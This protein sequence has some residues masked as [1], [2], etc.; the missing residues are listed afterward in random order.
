MAQRPGGR[1]DPRKVIAR[2][3]LI[4]PLRLHLNPAWVRL[5][6]LLALIG[7]LA[8]RIWRWRAALSFGALSAMLYG[9][10]SR[11]EPQRPVLE[12][13]TLFPQRLTVA[14]DGLRIGQISDT[15][16]GFR[17]TEANLAWAVAQ[18]RIE[19]PDLIVLTGDFV[20]TASAIPRLAPLLRDLHAPLGVYAVLGNH[21]DW[22]GAGDVAAA[23]TLCGI[24]LL[25]NTQCL[26]VWQGAALRIAG[27]DDVWLGAL[28][29]RQT[30]GGLPDDVFTILLA[31][32]PDVV[33]ESARY[34]VD[35]QLSGHSH[36]GQL[37][38]PLLG[39]LSAPRYGRRY[40]IG[41]HQVGPTT[42]YISRGSGGVPL[43]LLCPPEAT[44][45]TLRRRG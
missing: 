33:T 44:I 18:M 28:D 16:L 21:D 1:Q 34:G 38:L 10:M 26:H 15:H 4:D 24:T 30:L 12:R 41:T 22:E 43:R 13:V 2:R 39:Q 7:T 40:I 8:L 25:Y 23:L 6:V 14:L 35:L 9:Y 20:S 37:R 11:I 27:I 17:Y 31:H 29:M 5:A 45:I 32:A 3:R 42:L 19:Q 36:G